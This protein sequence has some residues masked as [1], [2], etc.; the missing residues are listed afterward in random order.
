MSNAENNLVE[1]MKVMLADSYL[2]MLKTQ[3]YHW[4]V[5][6]PSFFS[7]HTLFEEQYRELF[8]ANDEIAERILA[9]GH[10]APGSYEA[11]AKLANIKEETETIDSST[12][13]ERLAKDHERLAK[14]AQ[15]LIKAAEAAND[16]VSVDLGVRRRDV[17]QKAHWMLSSH[18][19]KK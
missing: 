18:L 3:N 1:A 9:I 5:K 16:D 14:D 12:M 17:H 10:N 13:V 4:N 6:G 7:L 15:E 8:E 2:L 19:E 11:F